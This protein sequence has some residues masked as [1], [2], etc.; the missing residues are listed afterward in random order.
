MEGAYDQWRTNI[1][2]S[3]VLGDMWMV[4]QFDAMGKFVQRE[5]L[6]DIVRI[7]TD[8]QQH[9][10]WIKRDMELGFERII[11]HNANRQQEL[12]I[13]DFGDKVLPF[14]K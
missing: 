6:V 11:L 2:D 13:T 5:E 1:F 7:S 4:E 3:T 9:V 12:F 14:L 8:A 10:D